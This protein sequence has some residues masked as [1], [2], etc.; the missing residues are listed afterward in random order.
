[1]KSVKYTRKITSPDHLKGDVGETKEYDDYL[2]QD[3]VDEGFAEWAEQ[4][5][6]AVEGTPHEGTT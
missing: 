4:Q 2:A 1:M 6:Q 5:K 3:L